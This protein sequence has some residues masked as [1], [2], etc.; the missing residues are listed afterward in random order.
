MIDVRDVAAAHG[1][2]PS[3]SYALCTRVSSRR[4]PL[5]RLHPLLCRHTLAC[6]LRATDTHTQHARTRSRAR[7]LCAATQ[8]SIVE[9][10]DW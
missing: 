9:T 4:Q 10:R 8:A 5:L 3:T 1:M 7:G 6:L 2:S